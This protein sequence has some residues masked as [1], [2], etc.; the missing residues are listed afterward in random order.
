MPN[1]CRAKSLAGRF[2]AQMASGTLFVCVL[3]WLV[4]MVHK[5]W[6]KVVHGWWGDRFP[7]SKFVC[8]HYYVEFFCLLTGVVT[9]VAL[10]VLILRYCWVGITNKRHL[11]QKVSDK[12]RQP[13]ESDSPDCDSQKDELY[14]DKFVAHLSDLLEGLEEDSTTYVGL[15]GEWG[16]GKSW[17]LDSL[18]KDSIKE[19]RLLDFVEICPWR[20]SSNGLESQILNAIAAE[21]H[22]SEEGFASV[23]KEYGRSFGISPRK[24]LLDDIP[25]VGKWVSY[26]YDCI[27]DSDALKKRVVKALTGYG[28]RIVVAIEDMDRLEYWEVRKIIRAIRTNCD[29]PNVTYLLMADEEYLAKAIGCNIGGEEIGRRYLS[30]IIDFPCQ[31]PNVSDADLFEAY[32]TRLVGYLEKEWKYA[33]TGEDRQRLAYLMG[34]FLTMRDV[35]RAVNSFITEMSRQK[36]K[37]Q[38]G[39]PNVDWVDLAGLA[40]VKVLE[41]GLYKRLR[42][43][44]WTLYNIRDIKDATKEFNES[45][46]DNV[47][48][49]IVNPRRKSAIKLFMKWSMGIDLQHVASGSGFSGC[50]YAVDLSRN[51]LALANHSLMSAYCVDNYF[52]G[53]D[54]ATSVPNVA[55]S[56][57]LANAISDDAK[58]LETAKSISKDGKLAYLAQILYQFRSPSNGKAWVTYIASLMR[59]ADENW[60]QEQLYPDKNVQRY[61]NVDIYGRFVMAIEGKIGDATFFDVDFETAL[62]RTGAFY[63]GLSVVSHCWRKGYG[64]NFILAGKPQSPNAERIINLIL[65]NSLIATGTGQILSHP[66]RSE[67]AEE[68]CRLISSTTNNELLGLFRSLYERLSSLTQFAPLMIVNSCKEVVGGAADGEYFYI[69]DYQRF[70]KALGEELAD[71]VIDQLNA[72]SGHDQVG[73][74]VR[75]ILDEIKRIREKKDAGQPYDRETLM[76]ELRDNL[77]VLQQLTDTRPSLHLSPNE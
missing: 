7:W 24:G 14:R 2:L 1:F 21:A 40:A 74:E 70:E 66:H 9:W 64:Y 44:Y 73:Q 62:K 55:Q 46:M 23:I 68:I 37:S 27:H 48:L 16:A 30:K 4:P 43:T 29:I 77:E 71:V 75:L 13:Y 72:L 10:I 35:K 17:V 47:V 6:W 76:K 32:Y 26:R 45:W 5:H 59:I 61:S 31:L 11:A 53:K 22:L 28:R 49:A 12:E 33:V 15:Y 34:L 58:A 25:L 42:D 67:M 51:D 65:R 69:L 38:G 19:D 3:L 50:Y 18:R 60:P 41:P 20:T 56:E 63:I 57:F 52:T 8:E 36:V 39:V 54:C